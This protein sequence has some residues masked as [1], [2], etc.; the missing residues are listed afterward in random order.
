MSLGGAVEIYYPL[1]TS[2]NG[3]FRVTFLSRFSDCTSKGNGSDAVGHIYNFECV[4]LLSDK[5]ET[6]Q[7]NE[8]V[9]F[10]YP[11]AGATE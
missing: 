4:E 1:I 8:W 3:G 7:L 5:R 6:L 9:H 11:L 2:P 10:Q